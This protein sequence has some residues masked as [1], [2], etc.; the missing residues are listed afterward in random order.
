M[1]TPDIHDLVGAYV[2]NAVEPDES[3]SFEEHLEDCASCRADVDGLSRAASSLG[4]TITEAP[5]PELWQRI[6]ASAESTPQLAPDV[7]RTAT[8]TRLSRRRVL[9]WV[10]AAAV[11]A[12]V[13]GGVAG[14]VGHLNSGGTPTA[15]EVFAATDAQVRTV[16]TD[17]GNV[18]LGESARLGLVAVDTS[19]MRSPGA[20]HTYQLWLVP[21][22]GSPESLA[23][24]GDA[25]S[26]TAAIGSGS[27]AVTVEPA[28]GSRQPTT[29]PLFAVPV[30]QL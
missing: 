25:T 27:L 12:A 30:T 9:Q 1:P 29:Q 22:S 20:G 28:G 2:L 16:A 3:V 15:A 8:V 24:F 23:V 19:S 21:R 7:P 14:V 26:A 18:R 13:G 4:T 11:V 6:R 5:P 10:A 17:R